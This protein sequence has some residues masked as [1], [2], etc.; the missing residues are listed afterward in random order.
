MSAKDDGSASGLKT[1]LS[2]GTKRH[3]HQQTRTT[4]A[5]PDANTK[6]RSH[7]QTESTTTGNHGKPPKTV[8][9]KRLREQRRRAD[10]SERFT[11]LT[12]ALREIDPDFRGSSGAFDNDVRGRE[13]TIPPS[14]TV[15]SSTLNRLD[16]I[17]HTIS[18]LR[19]IH[20]E[21]ETR[22]GIIAA[23]Q[24][25]STTGGAPRLP[26]HTSRLST[27]LGHPGLV[28]PQPQ[29]SGFSVSFQFMFL[30]SVGV[31]SDSRYECFE[32]SRI[33]ELNVWLVAAWSE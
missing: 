31:S 1:E 9:K 29:F 15:D 6:K 24:L 23:H 25:S 33:A 16:I 8:E 7:S 26:L 11:E 30:L 17:T 21:N 3:G 2:S 22:R 19:R 27:M 5:T 20:N 12:S 4:L 14:A 13:S 32:F 10:L 28:Q 18:T